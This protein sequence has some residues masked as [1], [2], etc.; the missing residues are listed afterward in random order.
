MGYTFINYASQDSAFV[1]K[2]VSDLNAVGVGT[3]IDAD[4]LSAG[5][6]FA[7]ALV[8]AVRN[9]DAM[10]IVVS[11]HS[12]RSQ[13]VIS[14]L[15]WAARF[16]VLMVPFVV[17][18]ADAQ[19]ILSYMRSF[20]IIDARKNY[21]LALKALVA[22]M[23]DSAKQGYKPASQGADAAKGY[24]FLS[25]ANEDAGFVD[26]LKAYLKTRGYSY[27]DYRETNRDYQSLLN[28]EL[29]RAIKSA[30]ATICMVSDHWK[31]S[32]WTMNE[33]EYSRQ[34]GK[35]TL[36]LK[37]QVFEPIARIAT[38][39]YIDFTQSFDQGARLLDQALVS[40]GLL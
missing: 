13:W 10:I 1:K 33:F 15:G 25:Y 12:I 7:N 28:V 40:F 16:D 17:D 2:L 22:I 11:Q 14:E 19:V 4:N 6:N 3:W 27:W 31:R 23:P 8:D 39:T 32:E 35:P 30:R 21:D 9:A 18:D 26:R 34:I 38:H 36:L 37:T 24:V 20:Q 29:E 5:T